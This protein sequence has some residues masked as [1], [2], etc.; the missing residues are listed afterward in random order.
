MVLD[1][2]DHLPVWLGEAGFIDLKIE[3]RRSPIGSWGGELG[4]FGLRNI[5]S[6]WS[7]VK[8]LVM[9]EKG[10]GV[11]EDEEAYDAVVDDLIKLCE[12]TPGTYM[13]YWVFTVQKP[14][15]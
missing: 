5:M 3:K 2:V 13:E 7:A 15:A 4:T 14:F 1:V 9:K 12:E 10:F 11:V 6:F 8:E